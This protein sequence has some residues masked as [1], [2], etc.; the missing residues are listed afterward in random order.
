MY[1]DLYCLF[2]ERRPARQDLIILVAHNDDPTG[3]YLTI[4]SVVKV[5]L[6]LEINFLST[7]PEEH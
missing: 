3:T 6:A 5:T 2:S 7:G 4:Y 1:N